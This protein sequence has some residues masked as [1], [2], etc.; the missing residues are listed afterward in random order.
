MRLP[1]NFVESVGLSVDSP[2]E[3]IGA[4]GGSC[5]PDEANEIRRLYGL[6]L[7][8]VTSLNALAVMTGF[9]PGFVWSLVNR[10][11]KY[12]RV[13]TIPKGEHGVKLKLPKL[14]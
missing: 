7:P 11:H 5:P 9:N 4:L 2:D 10:P 14:P 12:Y 1:H 13:F 8:P 6:G 3:L